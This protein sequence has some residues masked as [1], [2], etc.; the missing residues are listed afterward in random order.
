MSESQLAPKRRRR[1]SDAEKVARNSAAERHVDGITLDMLPCCYCESLGLEH[2]VTLACTGNTGGF[3][4]QRIATKYKSW[5]GGCCSCCTCDFCETR[6]QFHREQHDTGFGGAGDFHNNH[7]DLVLHD[8]D[9]DYFLED[10]EWPQEDNIGVVE[11]TV[12]KNIE[13][14]YNAACLSSDITCV[15]GP[16][17]YRVPVLVSSG[18][19]T[20]S[21]DDAGFSARCITT[22]YPDVF[23][24]FTIHPLM[25][26]SVVGNMV[27]FVD[28]IEAEA[29]FVCNC[30]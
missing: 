5:E 18:R 20:S 11:E 17:Q 22:S 28:R 14:Q 29:V 26:A 25:I 8:A 27:R 15:C 24:E 1:F 2:P 23:G 10:V 3:T 7:Q 6:L 19:D 30:R 4:A 21:G 12:E 16:M 9:E 13:R